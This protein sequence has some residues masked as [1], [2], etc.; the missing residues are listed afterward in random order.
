MAV[1]TSAWSEPSLAPDRPPAP[2]RRLW[3]ALITPCYAPSIGGVETHVERVATRLAAWGH[4][5]DVLTQTME[6]D[7]V[8]VLT[9]TTEQDP[10]STGPVEGVTVR[11]F[12]VPLASHNGGF[13]PG[14]WTYLSRHGARYDIVHAHHYHTLPALSAVLAGCRPLVFTPHYHGAGHS[15]LRSLLHCPYRRIGARLFARADRVICN[16][17]AEADLVRRDFPFVAERIG[18]VYP[19]VDVAALRLAHPYPTRR[20]VVLT[21]GR[22]EGYK[23]IHKTIEALAYLDDTFALHVVGVGPALPALHRLAERLG[24]DD[25]VVFL[26]RASDEEVRRWYRTAAVFVSLSRHEAFGLTLAE[27]LAAGAGVVASDIPAHR[28][29]LTRA[30]GAT[31]ALLPL[32]VAPATLAHA[33]GDRAKDAHRGPM[34]RVDSWDDVAAGTLAVYRAV[35][36]P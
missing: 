32:D 8:D 28:E 1:R 16:S 10:P 18:V 20:T 17:R 6:Q 21:V 35:V 34:Y 14:L 13:A 31:S 11:R 33:I 15:P 7:R 3:I 25:R 2:G 19:G 26:G 4:R 23:N 5:V 12:R 27:A 36:S 29:T 30:A 22:L 24:V 9:Q